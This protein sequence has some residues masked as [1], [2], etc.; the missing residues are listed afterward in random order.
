LDEVFGAR[1]TYVEFLADNNI[2][3]RYFFQQYE[4]RGGKAV[5]HYPDG[6]IA[7]VENNLGSGRTLLMGSFPGG[8]YYLHHGKETRTL[9]TSF[10][11]MAGIIPRLTVDDNEVQARVHQGA[12]GTYLW[13]TNPTTMARPVTVSLNPGLGRFS[14]G[15]DKWG[16][17]NRATNNRQCTRQGWSRHCTALDDGNKQP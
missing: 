7:A 5:G 13:V 17:L 12:G 8:G 14:S 6:S 3:G 1:E 15:E 4:T 2:Y 9:F 16:N 10:L 11:K